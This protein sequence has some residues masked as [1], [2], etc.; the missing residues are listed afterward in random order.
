[1]SNKSP[2][3]FS[4]NT[5]NKGPNKPSPKYQRLEAINKISKKNSEQKILQIFEKFINKI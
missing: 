4:A 2:P 1:M 5:A 3:T